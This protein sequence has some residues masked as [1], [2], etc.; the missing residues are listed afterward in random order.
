MLGEHPADRL[1]PESRPFP[2]DELNNQLE[3]RSSSAAKKADALFKIA[4]ARRNSA[5]SRRS[6]FNSAS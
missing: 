3:G 6:F 4:L 1:D 2:I 5:F